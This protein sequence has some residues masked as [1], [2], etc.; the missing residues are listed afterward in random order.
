[1]DNEIKNKLNKKYNLSSKDYE[2]VSA[3]IDELRKAIKDVLEFE[4]KNKLSN[5]PLIMKNDRYFK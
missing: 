4:D 1:M 2:L 3:R 5:N